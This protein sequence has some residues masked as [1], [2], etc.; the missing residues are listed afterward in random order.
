MFAP[1]LNRI[2][3]LPHTSHVTSTI[4][5]GTTGLWSIGGR[6]GIPSQISRL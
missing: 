1:L 2:T 5:A 4:G 3:F 6:R